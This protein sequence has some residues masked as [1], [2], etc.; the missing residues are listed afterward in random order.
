M[1]LLPTTLRMKIA[2]TVLIWGAPLLLAP[3]ALLLWLGFPEVTPGL[4]RRLLGAAYLALAIGYTGGLASYDAG[5]YPTFVVAMG[6]VSNGVA[7]V[8]IAGAW[9]TGALADWGTVAVA[10]MQFSAL[11]TA[12]ITSALLLSWFSRRDAAPLSPC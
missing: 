9:V 4:F 1:S 8:L 7:A 10:Y 11:V 6:I 5:R 2:L 12:G 3:D